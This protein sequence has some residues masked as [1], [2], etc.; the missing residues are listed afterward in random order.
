MDKVISE[1]FLLSLLLAHLRIV[2]FVFFLPFFSA[3]QIPFAVRLYFSV[4]LTLSLLLYTEI[5]PL[6]VNTAEE[7]LILAFN[8]FLF[9]FV[10]VLILRLIFD[11]MLIAGEIIAV[12]TA[13]GF[14]QVFLPGQPQMS[15]FSAFF[16]LYA[17]LIFLSLGGAEIVILALAESLKELP[18]GSFNLFS[19]NP[20]VYLRFFYES[21][22]L[23]VK[24]SLPV[25]IT[26]LLLNLVLAVVNRFIPQMNVFMVG[27]PL[28]VMLGLIVLLL[29][30]PIIAYS[31][32]EHLREIIEIFVRFVTYS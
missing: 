32:S 27:L 26:A 25:L 29:S 17:T 7:V 10:S 30:L 31:F 15:L 12:H 28:Q 22:S 19:L 5:P 1:E 16:S 13:M 24:L 6:R 18:P 8:E 11:A 14:L 20:E 21:F 3:P 4:A 23:G 9:G 2:L